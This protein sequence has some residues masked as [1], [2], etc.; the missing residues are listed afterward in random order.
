ML[1]EILATTGGVKSFFEVIEFLRSHYTEYSVK[2]ALFNPDGDLL[3]G[4]KSIVVEKIATGKDE[5]WYYRVRPVDGYEFIYMPVIPSVSI[6]FGTL[7]GQKNPDA[8]IFR[9]V[10]NPMA[11]FTSGGMQNVRTNFIVFAYKP[12]QLLSARKKTI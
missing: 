6:D 7:E 4:D 3:K 9:F 5:I 2:G 8:N 1:A 11:Y 12:E 10:P